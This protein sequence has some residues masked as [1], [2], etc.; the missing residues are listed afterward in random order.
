MS[1]AQ[2][3][4]SVAQLSSILPLCND[5]AFQS[6]AVLLVPPYKYRHSM[7][8]TMPSNHM[9]CRCIIQCLV[10]KPNPGPSPSRQRP[11]LPGY[12]AREGKSKPKSI[13][14]QKQ[15]R[16][17]HIR[18]SSRASCSVRSCHISHTSPCPCQSPD[19]GRRTCCT[20][21]R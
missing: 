1:Q 19:S 20:T 14:R 17:E 16:Q 21:A 13:F 4:A 3:T 10:N 18:R 8:L 7:Q 2:L 12:F 11:S 15:C 6:V 9:A 5:L